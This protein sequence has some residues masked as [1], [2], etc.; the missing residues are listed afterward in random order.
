MGEIDAYK[1][2]TL[3]DLAKETFN[4]K[5]LEIAEILTERTP[6]IRTAMMAEANSL[7]SHVFD[8]RATEPVG[9]FTAFNQGIPYE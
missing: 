9:I 3:V 7:T 2:Y 1:S 6:V 5:V 4:K 8:T